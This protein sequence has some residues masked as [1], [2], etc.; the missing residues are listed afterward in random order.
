MNY[1]WLDKPSQQLIYHKDLEYYKRYVSFIQWGKNH[2]PTTRPQNY[3][4]TQ[5]SS[6]YTKTHS[7]TFYVMI[8]LIWISHENL[9]NQSY[10]SDYTYSSYSTN[11]YYAKA[12]I[13]FRKIF[14]INPAILWN[15][16]THNSML[17]VHYN[18]RDSL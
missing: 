11:N 8:S 1:S 3:Q 7:L 16:S 14:R 2:Q 15:L 5:P 17:L 13:H 12:H 4:V 9:R 18:Q 10:I 6:Y